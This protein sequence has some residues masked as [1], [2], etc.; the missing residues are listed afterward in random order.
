MVLK[1]WGHHIL[2]YRYP[3][4]RFMWRQN[5]AHLGPVGPRRAHVG[6]INFAIRVSH[7]TANGWDY[8]TYSTENGFSF[9]VP[10]YYDCPIK[11]VAGN[12]VS[13]LATLV[14]QGFIECITFLIYRAICILC[15]VFF[16]KHADYFGVTWISVC[17]ECHVL[18]KP[19]SKCGIYD[20]CSLKIYRTAR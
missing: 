19:L 12:P 11:H 4:T 7:I 20:Y 2:G 9:I 15:L 13:I 18:H 5:G 16:N 14:I 17:G 8:R 1:F 3:V 10:G 6:P